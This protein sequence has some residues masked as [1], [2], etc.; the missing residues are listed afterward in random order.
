M[1]A[2]DNNDDHER[3]TRLLLESEQVMLRSILVM[4]PNRADAREIMQDTAV[5]LWRQF[6]SY[7]PERPFINWAMGFSRIETRRFLARQQRRAQLTEEA[8]AVLEQEMKQAPEFG[9]AVEDHLATCLGKLQGK[10]RRIIKGYYHD[11]RSPEWLSEQEGRTVDAIYKALQRIRRA[12][13]K[14]IETQWKKELT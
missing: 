4:V 13:Q 8:I 5:A 7:D 3:F 10:Q 1:P 11:G 2:T 14:C 12:L 6:D 9:A